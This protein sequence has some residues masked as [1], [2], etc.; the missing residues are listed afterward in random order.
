MDYL[1]SAVDAP[2]VENLEKAL[3]GTDQ[4]IRRQIGTSIPGSQGEDELRDC[5]AP[6]AGELANR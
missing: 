1:L 6:H 2:V 4:K 3:P 5:S